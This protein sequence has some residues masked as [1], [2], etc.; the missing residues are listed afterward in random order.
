MK[1]SRASF[2]GVVILVALVASMF[3]FGIEKADG[4]LSTVPCTRSVR[5]Y[6]VRAFNCL[7]TYMESHITC[8]DGTSY[9][10]TVMI[11]HVC[12]ADSDDGE[13]LSVGDENV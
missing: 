6:S 13:R 1:Y 5:V 8:G 4:Q 9:Q 10:S 7:T 12:Y 11:A 2:R 3:S